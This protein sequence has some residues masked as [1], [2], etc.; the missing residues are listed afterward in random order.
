VQQALGPG[1]LDRRPSALLCL[2]SLPGEQE[3]RR[4]SGPPTLTR[5]LGRSSRRTLP[6]VKRWTARRSPGNGVGT[7]GAGSVPGVKKQTEQKVEHTRPR[8]RP[9]PV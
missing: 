7:A 9:Q 8:L 3:G 5:K 1:A 4:S 2:P 6:G